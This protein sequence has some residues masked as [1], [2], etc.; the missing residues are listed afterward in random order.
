METNP[1]RSINESTAYA[2]R[3]MLPESKPI[4]PLTIPIKDTARNPIFVVLSPCLK[5]ANCS[6]IN[7][8]SLLM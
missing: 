2:C 5:D 3:E 6:V 7:F 8:S 4:N 1:K